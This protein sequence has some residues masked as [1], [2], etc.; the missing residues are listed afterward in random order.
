MTRITQSYPFGAIPPAWREMIQNINNHAPHSRIHRSEQSLSQLSLT[1]PFTQGRLFVSANLQVAHRERCG[2][3]EGFGRCPRKQKRRK[4]SPALRPSQ[5]SKICH[6]EAQ[7]K[8]L[9]PDDFYMCGRF[10]PSFRMTWWGSSSESFFLF[11]AKQASRSPISVAGAI[12]ESPGTAGASPHHAKAFPLRGRWQPEGLT[13]EVLR[14]RYGAA[15][16]PSV[17]PNP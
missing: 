4:Q 8:N 3:T 12:H 6:S 11:P 15:D 16:S 17:S 7:P 9:R 5:T 2:K 1:A 14:Q 10:F 13:D